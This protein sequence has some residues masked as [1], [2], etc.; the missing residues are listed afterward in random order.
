[1]QEQIASG[2]NAA[3]V[4]TTGAPGPHLLLR[5]EMMSAV[6][7]QCVF[8][9]CFF[10]QQGDVADQTSGTRDRH[11]AGTVEIPRQELLCQHYDL[12]CLRKRYLVFSDVL[13]SARVLPVGDFL[14]WGDAGTQVP[15]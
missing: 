7:D 3:Y 11:T 13:Y 8:V 5:T 15:F 9:V 12:S 1:M 6:V 10:R 14:L 4:D 2:T